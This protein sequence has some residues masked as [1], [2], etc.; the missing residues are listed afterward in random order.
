MNGFTSATKQGLTSGATQ[1]EPSKNETDI[2]VGFRK[3]ASSIELAKSRY[4][5]LYDRLMPIRKNLPHDPESADKEE[6]MVGSLIAQDLFRAANDIEIL[7]RSID[8]TLD[9]LQV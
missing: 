8:H 2:Q 6:G 4:N 7:I 9:E 3:L 1:G 5:I